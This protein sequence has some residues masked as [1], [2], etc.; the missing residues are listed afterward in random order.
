M[1]TGL[2]VARLST[3]EGGSDCIACTLIYYLMLCSAHI[4]EKSTEC[5]QRCT[6]SG[7]FVALLSLKG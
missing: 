5:I 7:H 4:V 1:Y 3:E 2:G 6:I